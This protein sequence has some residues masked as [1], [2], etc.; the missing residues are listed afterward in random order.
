MSTEIERDWREMMR[1]GKYLDDFATNMRTKCMQTK[2]HIDAARP[3]V[4]AE[5]AQKAMDSLNQSLD[6]IMKLLPGVSDFGV[7]MKKKAKYLQKAEEINMS[8]KAR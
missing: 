3:K 5:N 8:G 4:L 6:A 1:F 7:G 2:A